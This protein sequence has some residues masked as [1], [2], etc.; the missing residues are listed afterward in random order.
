M[1]RVAKPVN[2]PQYIHVFKYLFRH[3]FLEVAEFRRTQFCR[4]RPAGPLHGLVRVDRLAS[5]PMLVVATG[6]Y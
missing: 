5:G 3:G 4:L 6:L 1:R 2:M